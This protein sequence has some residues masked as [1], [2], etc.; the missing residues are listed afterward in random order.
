MGRST[1]QVVVV[2]R[3]SFETTRLSPQYLVEA[4]ARILPVTRKPIASVG[5]VPVQTRRTEHG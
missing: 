5:P 1:P 3:I 2:A 4:Y